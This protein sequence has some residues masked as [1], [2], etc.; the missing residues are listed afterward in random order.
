MVGLKARLRYSFILLLLF[1]AQLRAQ[2]CKWIPTDVNPQTLDS[3][4]VIPS[5][6]T[7]PNNKEVLFDFDLKTNSIQFPNIT[8]DSI[9]IC[10]RTLPFDLHTPKANRILAIYDSTALFKDALQY[11]E[12]LVIPKREEVFKTSNIARTG[13]ISR[14]VSFG[15][16]QDVF[17]NSTLNFQMEGQ[18]SDDVNIRAVITD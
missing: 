9:Y 10:Y 2:D 17:V 7:F 4:T 16:R 15:N 1:G 6:I 8:L 18:L 12:S 14:R 5:T 13:S 3:L 11:Q